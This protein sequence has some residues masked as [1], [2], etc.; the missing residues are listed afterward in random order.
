MADYILIRKGRNALSTVTH[1]ILNLLLGVGSILATVAIGW[2][3]GILLVLVSKWRMF[4]VRPR[5]WWPNLKANLV[6]LSVGISFV[7]LA[8]IGLASNS[9]GLSGMLLV[10]WLLAIGYT[11]WL[12]WV[13]PRSSKVFTEVQALV[14]LFLGTSAISLILASYDAVWVSLFTFI[15][16]SACARHVMNQ[17]DDTNFTLSTLVVGLLATEFMWL[18]HSWFIIYYYSDTGIYIPQ[19][20]II[21]TLAGFAL[22]R[23]YDSVLRHDGKF[24]GEEILQPV[25]FSVVTAVIIFVIFNNPNYNI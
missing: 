2:Q 12:I 9:T 15:L 20:A 23:V 21:L 10:H 18:A 16:A 5:Y 6:D 1:V 13:K 3:L 24:K 11:V 4:A 25:L 8:Q 19:A 17:R 7:L 14:A 22:S